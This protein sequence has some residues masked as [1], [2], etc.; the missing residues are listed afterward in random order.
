MNQES[1]EIKLARIDERTRQTQN[2]IKE[3]KEKLD[4][5]YVTQD[6]FRPVRSIVYGLVGL[7]LTAFAGGIVAMVMR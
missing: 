7:I 6:E 1:L 5:N 4:K 2:V 3:I